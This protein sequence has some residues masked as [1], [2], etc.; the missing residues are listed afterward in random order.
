MQPKL[1]RKK[2]VSK[3]ELTD[4]KKSSRYALTHQQQDEEGE[5]ITN[6]IKVGHCFSIES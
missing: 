4:T 1:N 5:V 6:I 2:S 3:I